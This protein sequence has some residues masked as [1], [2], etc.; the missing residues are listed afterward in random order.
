LLHWLHNHIYALAGLIAQ[1]QSSAAVRQ[2][3]ELV[4]ESAANWKEG[5]QANRVP[6]CYKRN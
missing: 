6:R 4:D 2:V 1:A 3:E 5:L